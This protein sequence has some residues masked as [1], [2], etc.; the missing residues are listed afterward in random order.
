MHKL[1]GFTL[2]DLY[3]CMSYEVCLKTWWMFRFLKFTPVNDTLPLIP[4]GLPPPTLDTLMP[5]FS[6]LSAAALQVPFMSVPVAQLWLPWCLGKCQNI[7]CWS[8][9]VWGR[10]GSCKVPRPVNKGR[11]TSHYASQ[12]VFPRAG[13]E[14]KH[15]LCFW[16]HIIKTQRRGLPELLQKTLRIVG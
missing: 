10:A 5:S 16:L 2:T 9:W 13:D 15:S 7:F 3:M 14:Q 6:P 1:M 8:L 4:S 11:K 12:P